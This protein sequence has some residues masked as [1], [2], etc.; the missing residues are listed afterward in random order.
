LQCSCTLVIRHR[1]KAST[2]EILSVVLA[3][4]L[5]HIDNARA[6]HPSYL[7][8][9]KHSSSFLAV[10]VYAFSPSTLLDKLKGYPTKFMTASRIEHI[11]YAKARKNYSRTTSRNS[12]TSSLHAPEVLNFSVRCETSWAKR[13]P[14]ILKFLPKNA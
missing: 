13:A 2:L 9:I 4:N 5:Q 7:T 10:V 1:R 11:H 8:G 6:I 14:S 12:V 3:Q